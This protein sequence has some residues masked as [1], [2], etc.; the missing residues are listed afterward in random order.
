MK[1]QQNVPTVIKNNFYI[2]KLGFQI[3]PF[4]VSST[5]VVKLLDYLEKFYVIVFI[6]FLVDGLQNGSSFYQL[7]FLVA[8]AAVLLLLIRTAEVLYGEKWQPMMEQ[9]L[10]EKM[11]LDLFQKAWQ[12]DLA[13]FEDP[14]FYGNYTKAMNETALRVSQTIDNLSILLGSVVVS[15]LYLFKLSSIDLFAIIVVI[16]PIVSTCMVAPRLYRLE[17]QMNM[18]NIEPNRKKEYVKRTV[19]LK[20]FAQEI[21]LSSIFQVLKGSFYQAV[22]QIFANIKKYSYK[23]MCMRILQRLLAG[24]FPTILF[25]I[26][27]SYHCL[28]TQTVSISGYTVVFYGV[29][30][31]SN[32]LA[33]LVNGIMALQQHSLYIENYK[34]FLDYC[35][36]IQTDV[37]ALPIPE[38]LHSLELEDVSFCYFG[39][40]SP[41]LSHINLTICLDKLEKIAIV[42]NN[43]AGKSTLIK[44][45]LRLYDPTEGRILLNG[46]DIRQFDVLQYRALFGTVFQDFTIFS[47]SV[48]ENVK[49]KKVE[50][51]DRSNIDAALKAGGVW[52][53]ICSFPQKTDTILTREFDDDGAIL[54]GGESQKIAIARVFAS[55]SQIAILDE[56]SSALDPIAES[57]MFDSIMKVC[58]ERSV[59]FISHRL[60]SC[61]LCDRIY[62]FENGRII[63][64][65]APE[66]LR[67]SG[68]K[69]QEMFEKQSIHYQ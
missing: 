59:I 34:T 4:L 33:E 48:A 2:L 13:C 67:N 49:M 40:D 12:A 7:V 56:P 29:L 26:Y 23:M 9:T 17:Y 32:I 15:I 43:G 54:S 36:K 30:S 55:K 63:E 19:Y 69:Y 10:L 24:S 11:N 27:E 47:M 18:E 53:K 41:V 31:L 16:L 1:Q 57:R 50:K 3:C 25:L 64:E 5:F 42:G 14:E 58:K 21:R 38:K 22:E 37:S 8:L 66:F 61:C 39:S 65:G 28:V 20:N 60:S 52:E 44:L 46:V 35:P 45:L 62:H 6:E 51:T 68:G